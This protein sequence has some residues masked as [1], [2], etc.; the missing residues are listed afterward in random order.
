MVLGSEEAREES[1]LMV[2]GGL[3]DDWMEEELEVSS[4]DLVDSVEVSCD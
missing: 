3:E 1:D 2:V 4:V